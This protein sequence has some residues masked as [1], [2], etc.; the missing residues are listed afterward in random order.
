MTEWH[1]FPDELPPENGYYLV[2]AKFIDD[3]VNSPWVDVAY[4]N[5]VLRRF[6]CPC[7]KRSERWGVI[8]WDFC[9]ST[10]KEESDR[11]SK[12]S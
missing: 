5:A 6:Y 10:F 3:N 11:P 1:K 9:P 2:T 4:F 8:A 7:R 12:T